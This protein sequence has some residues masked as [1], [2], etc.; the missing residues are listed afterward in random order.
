VERL[1]VIVPLA[2]LPGATSY[3]RLLS[4]ATDAEKIALLRAYG[5]GLAMELWEGDR[6]ILRFDPCDLQ[7]PLSS[8]F[9][10]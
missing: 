2:D 1:V 7:G 4:C 8:I 3:A 5:D 9:R 10:E 6:L